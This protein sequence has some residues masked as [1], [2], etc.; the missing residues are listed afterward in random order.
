[1]FYMAVMMVAPMAI[2]MLAL[3]GPMYP[4]RR[5]N[6]ALYAAFAI[7]FIAAFGYT[8][9]ETFIGDEQFLRSMI[10]HHLGAILMCDEA[11]VSGPDIVDL[12][13]NPFSS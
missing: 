5:L 8:R 2:L 11:V 6:L 9:A 10:P 4:K 12:C 3:I 13:G 1:M 7:L